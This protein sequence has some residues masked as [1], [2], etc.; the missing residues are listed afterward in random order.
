VERLAGGSINAWGPVTIAPATAH[1]VFEQAVTALAAIHGVDWTRRLPGWSA[2]RTLDQ[3][4]DAW[5]PILVKGQNPAWT[6]RA[7]RLHDLLSRHRPDEPEPG[8]VHGDFYSNNWVTAGNR[9][10]GVVDW[11]SASVG[12]P[13][14]DLGWLMMMYD[15]QSWAPARQAVMDW[16]P[17]PGRIAET[18]AAATA[19]EPEDLGWYRALA[20]WR[21]ASITALN[22]RLH[23]SGQR[24]DALWDEIA[25][26]FEPM[27]D[28]GL[29]LVLSREAATL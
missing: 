20:A 23:R 15:P 26:S 5:T 3:E 1:D 21:L 18:Y 4:I 11:E 29:E 19:R 2:P 13:L 10:L 25:D 12:P 6:D 22:V 8:I 7:M 16:S 17:E 28:R 27:V 9:L 24:H 14:L